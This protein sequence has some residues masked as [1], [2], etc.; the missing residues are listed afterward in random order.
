MFG[1]FGRRIPDPLTV[2]TWL[3][4][5]LGALAELGETTLAR[6]ESSTDMLA[7]FTLL[8]TTRSTGNLLNADPTVINQIDKVY[9]EFRGFYDA[10]WQLTLLVKTKDK[11]PSDK[12]S[13][14]YA[15]V[16][17]RIVAIRR[18]MFKA[19]PQ[20]E[21]VFSEV[22]GGAHDAIVPECTRR[23]I[24]QAFAG[25]LDLNYH[26]DALSERIREASCTRL[27]AQET[28]GLLAVEIGDALNLKFLTCF[29][30][31]DIDLPD[32]PESFFK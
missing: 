26:V 18:A 17:V 28:W 22:I 23:Y 2:A 24:S 12:V 6:Q 3:E 11:M 19:N 5:M 30:L 1:L 31:E 25:G 9:V 15:F 10:L 16:D 7:L 20:I 8:S 29:R 32:L 14:L 4:N 27:S 21:K 13:N